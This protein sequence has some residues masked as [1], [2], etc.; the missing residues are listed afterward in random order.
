[1]TQRPIVKTRTVKETQSQRV[2]SGQGKSAATGGLDEP[3]GDCEAIERSGEY[4]LA[5]TGYAPASLRYTPAA[6]VHDAGQNATQDSQT[7]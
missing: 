4:T 3:H 6:G 1:M 2:E 5:W 7:G